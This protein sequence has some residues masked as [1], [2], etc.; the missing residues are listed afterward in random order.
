M[1]YFLALRL[2]PCAAPVLALLS[3]LF[4]TTALAAPQPPTQLQYWQSPYGAAQLTVTAVNVAC[5][6]LI[7]QV[8]L[9][10]CASFEVDMQGYTEVTLLIRYVYS[11][12]TAVQL[13]MDGSMDGAIPWGIVQAGDAGTV[14][15]ITMGDQ[16]LEW[17]TSVSTSWLVTFKDVN[18]SYVRWR[19]TSTGGGAGDTVVVWVV[20]RG[21]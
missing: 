16:Y 18:S 6:A 15:K 7:D 5:D 21:P 1:R 9:P 11:S 8:E 19:F 20:R 12:A 2:L 10:A 17:A 13:Y 4:A 3:L 14:P